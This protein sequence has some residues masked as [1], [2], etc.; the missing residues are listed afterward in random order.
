MRKAIVNKNVT[1][2]EESKAMIDMY[3]KQGATHL[4][5]V[6]DTFSYEDYHVP[7]NPCDNVDEVYAKYDDVN[8][9]RIRWCIEL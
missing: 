5:L 6:T 3:K 8:M 7:V 2:S 4:L 1:P 9:Q